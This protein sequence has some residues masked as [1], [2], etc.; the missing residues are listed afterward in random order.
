LTLSDGVAFNAASRARVKATVAAHALPV[1][2]SSVEP[3]GAR[4]G[5]VVA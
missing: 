3:H 1:A 4:V 5:E 2:L